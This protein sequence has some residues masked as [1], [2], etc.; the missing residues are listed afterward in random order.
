MTK[1]ALMDAFI[2]KR[3]EIGTQALAAALGVTDSAVR[4][5]C[6]GHYPSPAKLLAKFARQYIDIVDC[7]YALRPLER[8]DCLA[9]SS[10]PRPAGGAAKLT[11]WEACQTCE[12]KGEPQ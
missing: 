2:A 3:A 1:P 10:A 5:V 11:W 12:H 8:A 6:T 9:R 4:M 7:P